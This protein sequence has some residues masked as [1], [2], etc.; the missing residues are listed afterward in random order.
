MFKALVANWHRQ[1]LLFALGILALL[2]IILRFPACFEPY[3]YGDEGIYLTLG[4]A[5]NRGSVLYKDIIDHKTP[6]IYHLATVGSQHNF[7]ILLL[8]MMIAASTAFF[9]ILRQLTKKPL[10]SLLGAIAFSVI[11]ALPWYEGL[12]PN[13]ELFVMSF[14]LVGL[15]IALSHRDF[16]ALVRGAAP[17]SKMRS[18][19]MLVIAG[20]LFSLGILT[21]VPAVFDVAAAFFLGVLVIANQVLPW[22][23]REDHWRKSFV[24]VL[25]TWSWLLLGIVIPIL[26]SIA[27]FALRGALQE[28]FDYGLLYNFR[29]SG[30]W[31]P[32]HLG[33]Q[34]LWLTNLGVKAG[35]TAI[36][37]LGLTLLGSRVSLTLRWSFGWVL[38]ALFASLIS[39]R[40]YPHYFLQILPAFIILITLG[41]G[42]LLQWYR[43]RT[44]RDSVDAVIAVIFM[45]IATLFF[46]GAHLLVGMRPYVAGD[47]YTRF[48]QFATGQMTSVQYRDSFNGL[49]RDN[50][51]I[52]PTLMAEPDSTLFIWGTNPML[53]ALTNK[54]PVSRFTVQFHIKDFDA[55]LETLDRLTS[56]TP[57]FIVLMNDETPPVELKALLGARYL[58][59]SK[60][61]T[62]SA[63]KLR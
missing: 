19:W 6:V 27:Y 61:E 20:M 50:Y 48:Y 37:L 16:L 14:V 29:Y 13:G 57:S 28:Y 33:E 34:W 43:S 24:T 44:K 5:I 21:K 59:V 35:L 36:T 11:T 12:I 52:A 1:P 38:L 2:Q 56:E 45:L 58:R 60:F 18:S 3:W 10:I 22:S 47:Y 4:Q 31:S 32:D 23:K 15:A 55:E 9:W 17:S 42:E 8:G 49:M 25:K 63:Y 26:L 46:V 39:N 51:A 53:Y 54:T 41:A 7:R 30:S 40:P 62:F